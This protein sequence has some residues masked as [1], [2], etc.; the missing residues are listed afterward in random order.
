VY[1][2]PK[3]DFDNLELTPFGM[4]AGLHGLPGDFTPPSR[5][6]RATA[7]SHSI[8]PSETG[9]EAVDNAYRVLNLFNI[10]KG[11]VRANKDSNDY[12]QIT[13]ASN[14]KTKEYFLSTYDNRQLFMVDLKKMKR[15]T[16]KILLPAHYKPVIVDITP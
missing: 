1:S 3:V 16:E 10:P 7:F 4:G 12:T 15:K 14:T 13:V 5:F 11:V 9:Q 2:V 6:V 8:V